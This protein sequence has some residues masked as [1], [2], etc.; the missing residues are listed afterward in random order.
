MCTYLK[1]PANKKRRERKKEEGKHQ[2]G[3]GKI[4]TE[5]KKKMCTPHAQASFSKK[6]F[7]QLSSQCFSIDRY[8]HSFLDK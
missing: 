1:Q 4:G 8:L 5:K 6:R 2:V 3:G 7:L